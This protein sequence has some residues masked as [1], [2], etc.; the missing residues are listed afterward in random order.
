M[1]S[2]LLRFRLGLNLFLVLY[3]MILA[4]LIWL[5]GAS[6]Y[7]TLNHAAATVKDQSFGPFQSSSLHFAEMV[8]T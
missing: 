6:C 8:I 4:P 3:E 2:V 1:A 5:I 7:A